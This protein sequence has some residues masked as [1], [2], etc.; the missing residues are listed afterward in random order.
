MRQH[1]YAEGL[2]ELKRSVELTAAAGG[3]ESTNFGTLLSDVGDAEL[4]LGRTKEAETSLQK[5]LAILERKRGDSAENSYVVCSLGC[6]YLGNGKKPQ[7]QAT[8]RR[9]IRLSTERT[10]RLSTIQAEGQQL[11]AAGNLRSLPLGGWLTSTVDGD[12]PGAEIW[13]PVLALKGAVT[14]R[15]SA[16]HRALRG[17]PVYAEYLRVGRQLSEATLRPPAPPADLKLLAAWK[18]AEPEL[19]RRWLERREEL[20]R[21]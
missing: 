14:A 19:R 17:D 13:E 15:A 7:A 2:S 4:L 21:I 3:Q 12:L 20:A 9:A 6:A 10:N 1:R 8:F 11:D 16:T 18:D 5:A